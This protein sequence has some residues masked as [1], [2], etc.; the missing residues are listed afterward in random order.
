MHFF[1]SFSFAVSPLYLFCSCDSPFSS[2]FHFWRSIVL[3]DFFMSLYECSHLSPPCHWENP[4]QPRER[5]QKNEN[6]KKSIHRY[7]EGNLYLPFV[8]G[9]WNR[10]TLGDSLNEVYAYGMGTW[11]CG[12]RSGPLLNGESCFFLF[13]RVFAFAFAVCYILFCCI[14]SPLTLLYC[15]FLRSFPYYHFFF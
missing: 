8:M 14:S 5:E 3:Y 11:Q 12:T 6:E 15:I 1:L 7:P 2:F 9:S 13:L 10:R 4:R